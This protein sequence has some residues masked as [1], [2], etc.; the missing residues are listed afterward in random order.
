M[1]IEYLLWF[2]NL[3]E[4]TNNIFT[5][6]MQGYSDFVV[7]V[8]AFAPLLIY[9]CINKRNGLYLFASLGMSRFLNGVLKLTFCV[10]RPWIRDPR[11][12]PAEGSIKT[13]GGYSFPSGHTMNATPLLG[14]IGVI[15]RK[16]YIWISFLCALGI[17]LTAISRNYLG[18]HTPQDVVVGTALGLLVLYVA[19]KIFNYVDKNNEKENYFI[20]LGLILCVI[21]FIYIK[22]K[23][24]PMDYD[25]NGKIIV[26]PK[27]M[28]TNTYRDIGLFAGFLVGRYI[29]K[30]FIKF[31][32]TGL[33][34]KSILF[35]VIGCALYEYIH[36]G[37]DAVLKEFLGKDFGNFSAMFLMMFFAIAL[38]PFV[39][40]KFFSR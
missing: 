19:A 21:A 30:T 6:F 3:R 37:L 2:Q 22:N 38:W 20:I 8:L 13:A 1:D 35:L 7:S 25:S 11:I 34:L 10:Y 5:P 24:Y 4:S 12:I 16:K 17:I 39:L 32:P 40:K 15:C 18:V 27:K 14:G 28:I 9:W 29:E 33:N 31:S 36:H 26:E 23:S